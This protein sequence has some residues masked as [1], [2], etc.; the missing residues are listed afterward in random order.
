M[1]NVAIFYNEYKN[2]HVLLMQSTFYYKNDKSDN[3]LWG[4]AKINYT[5]LIKIDIL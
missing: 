5:Y 2:C 3:L 1:S 4:F